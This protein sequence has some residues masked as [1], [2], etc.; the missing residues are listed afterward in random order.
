LE[1]KRELR[2]VIVDTYAILAMGFSSYIDSYCFMVIASS[3][4]PCIA[5]WV[6]IRL[7]GV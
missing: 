5:S 3:L 2:A 6:C 1:K 4:F 7:G